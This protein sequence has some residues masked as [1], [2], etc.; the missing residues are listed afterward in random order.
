M[1]V[2][3]S[4]LKVKISAAGTRLRTTLDSLIS[5]VKKSGRKIDCFNN[6]T[7]RPFVEKWILPSATAT[8]TTFESLK[9]NDYLGGRIENA[10]QEILTNLG[11]VG[12]AV[13]DVLPVLSAASLEALVAIPATIAVANYSRHKSSAATSRVS[14]VLESNPLTKPV[15]NIYT[16]YTLPAITALLM[17]HIALTDVHPVIGAAL[18]ATAVTAST[19]IYKYFSRQKPIRILHRSKIASASPFVHLLAVSALGCSLAISPQVLNIAD[20]FSSSVVYLATKADLEELVNEEKKVM[21]YFSAVD[22][23]SRFYNTDTNIVKA[24]LITESGAR[25]RDAK[26]RI[27]KS[28]YGAKGIGQHLQI[29]I[30]ELNKQIALGNLPGEPFDWN[31]VQNNPSENIRATVATVRDL[32][33]T[34]VKNQKNIN[35]WELVAA[36]YNAGKTKISS[37]VKQVRANNFWQL[38]KRRTGIR[39]E[40]VQYVQKVMSFRHLYRSGVVWPT[41][42]QKNKT[43][44]GYGLRGN[45][46]HRGI[47]I[48]PLLAGQAGDRV[49]AIADGYVVKAGYAHNN[50]NYVKISHGKSEWGL[51]TVYL[52]GM[53]DSI[54][55]EPGQHVKAGQTIMHMGSTGKVKKRRNGTGVHLHLGLG[56]DLKIGKRKVSRFEDPNWMFR[57]KDIGKAVVSIQKEEPPAEETHFFDRILVGLGLSH[58]LKSNYT[59]ALDAYSNA[60]I[61]K[62]KGATV[63][64]IKF[65]KQALK[66]SHRTTLEDDIYEKLG[67]CYSKLGN[68][69]IATKFYQKGN[70]LKGD[71]KEELNR[72]IS[73]LQRRP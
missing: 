52:H 18:V 17:S 5:E 15:Y 60:N 26:G 30:N 44:S 10:Q 61:A 8:A 53:H 43:V 38:T 47:D 40:T 27:K 45:K 34:F 31:K 1:V 9:L 6:E 69:N 56:I 58:R 46:P 32:Q 64:A 42:G 54:R 50:G 25:H 68:R 57:T 22:Y 12:Y 59:I 49:R 29:N 23:Y 48:P 11:T 39:T 21:G 72:K 73:G 28:S 65:Y 63:S 66:L 20:S 70:S 67:D 35:E 3:M 62:Y 16:K 36:A 55:V 51:Y 19:S 2:K 14:R 24:I 71:R 4:D 33:N 7:V 37:A 41:E 13:T